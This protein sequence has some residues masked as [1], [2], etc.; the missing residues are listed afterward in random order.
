MNLASRVEVNLDG[1]VVSI[2]YATSTLEMVLADGR[3]ERFEL[4]S[5]CP[6]EFLV[7]APTI[8]E[9]GTTTLDLEILKFEVAGTSAVLWPGAPVK[10]SGGRLIGPEALPIY[11]SVRIPAG[12]SLADGAYSEQLVYIAVET[13]MGT[14]HNLEPVRMAAVINSVPPN[15]AFHSVDGTANL[16]LNK[17]DPAAQLIACTSVVNNPDE[18]DTT[19]GH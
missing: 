3:S 18:S 6:T 17:E 16:Y 11:G 4:K 10:M 8:D 1:S 14:M 15:Q 7:K 19:G 5:T 13:P 9:Q 12:Q 2:V